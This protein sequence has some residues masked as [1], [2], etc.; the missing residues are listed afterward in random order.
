MTAESTETPIPAPSRPSDTP[1]GTNTPQKPRERLNGRY[2]ASTKPRRHPNQRPT[3]PRGAYNQTT[4]AQCAD[5]HNG[6]RCW[7]DQGHTQAFPT[8]KHYD[9][10]TNTLHTWET[11]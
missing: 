10:T 7:L 9:P 2:V 6:L 11:P 3:H 4:P 5:T 1:S 8:H